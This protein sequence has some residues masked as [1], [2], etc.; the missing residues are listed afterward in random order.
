[1]NIQSI[2][3]DI[4]ALEKALKLIEKTENH[5]HFNKSKLILDICEQA[6]ILK[7]KRDKQEKFTCGA[8]KAVEDELLK[9]NGI[10]IGW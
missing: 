8:V 4:Q 2:N 6:N 9:P 10:K 7:E 3:K 1:M 5:L